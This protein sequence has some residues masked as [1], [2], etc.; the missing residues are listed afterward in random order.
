M[1]SR[2]ASFRATKPLEQFDLERLPHLNRAQVHDL[3][4]GR[5]LEE[6]AP[7]LIV[8]P[9]APA[10]AILRR[11]SGTAPCQGVDV[12][13]TSCA[14][15]TTARATGAYERRLARVPLLIVDDFDLKPLRPP[16]D[17]DLHDLFAERYLV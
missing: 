13:F 3:A 17:E 14:S 16:A 12:V 1:K 7:V 8:A 2:G 10:R 11:R 15:L 4:T 5:Y 6:H 9:A